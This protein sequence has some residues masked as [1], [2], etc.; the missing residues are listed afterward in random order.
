MSYKN[1]MC[2]ILNSNFD[3]GERKRLTYEEM[4][5]IKEESEKIR[6]EILKNF[7]QYKFPSIWHAI[8]GVCRSDLI[9]PDLR[10][11]D[12]YAYKQGVSINDI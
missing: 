2:E 6:K 8:S 4:M 9:V 10:Y 11:S 12:I 5:R 7:H 1:F 3:G